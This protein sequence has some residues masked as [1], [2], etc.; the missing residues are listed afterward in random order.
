VLESTGLDRPA[1]AE[2]GRVTLQRTKAIPQ[3]AREARDRLCLLYGERLRELI[4]FGS[5]A[6]GEAEPG[7][8]VDLLVVLKDFRD[9]EE[10]L[11]R[12]DPLASELSLKYDVVVSFLVIRARDYGERNTPLLLNIRREAIPL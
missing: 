4:L 1:K 7:S 10:E 2:K 6:R 12:M 8:D 5:H 3:V 11:M 9:S